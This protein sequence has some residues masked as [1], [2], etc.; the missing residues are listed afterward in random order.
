MRLVARF[1]AAGLVAA[2][3]LTGCTSPREPS[4]PATPSTTASDDAGARAA[5][6][7]AKLDDA[8]LVGQVLMP[9]VNMSDPGAA[10]VVAKYHLGGVILMG[11]VRDTAAGGTAA[12]V[13]A[14]T[15]QLRAAAGAK[16]GLIVGTDQEYGWVTRIKSGLVQ[17]PSA[18]AFGAAR[19]PDLT[20]LAWRGAGAELSAAGI[21]IDFAPDGDVIGSSANVIIGSRS[22]GSDPAAVAAQVTAAV[23]GLQS[24]GVAAAVK[25]FPGHGHT[26]GDSHSSLPVLSQSMVDLTANDLPPFQA[27]IDA[28][29][30]LVM[31]GHLDVRAIDRGLPASFSHKVLVDLLRTRMKFSGVVVT[32]ALNMSPA[33]R[34]PPSDAAVRALLAGN[35]LLLMPPDL[36]A[37]RTGLLSALASGRLPRARLVEAVTRVLTLK[38]RLA[39]SQRPDASTADG[40]A[41]RSAAQA[42]AA[43][44][45][46]VLRGPCAGALVTQPVRVTTSDGRTRQAA[47]LTEALRANGI[48]VVDTGGQVVHLVG[49]GDGP[50]DLAAGAAVTVAMDT[51]YVLRSAASPVRLATYSSTEVA[52][53][54]LADVLAGKATAPGRSPVAV[55]G[56]PRSACAV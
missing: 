1:A 12:E 3:A 33:L 38:F 28:G 16:V 45:V 42:V 26:T 9:S 25:H 23:H 2:L 10:E 35:D 22:Y 40:P 47:L 36:S 8:E 46:T 29:A 20:E 17:L 31:S 6:L 19:R 5:A 21:D 50:N 41:N 34:W 56:L 55:S 4:T 24:S 27:A 53:H 15:D 39:A 51:P 11:D 30:A 48:A 49:Y 14:Y 43:A 32:D 37:A 18:M 44:A 54:A 52:M 7:V 13:R